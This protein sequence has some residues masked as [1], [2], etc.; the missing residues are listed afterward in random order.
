[1]LSTTHTAQILNI[2]GTNAQVAHTLLCQFTTRW[3]LPQSSTLAPG[4]LIFLISSYIPQ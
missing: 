4:E 2:L 1:M 3:A